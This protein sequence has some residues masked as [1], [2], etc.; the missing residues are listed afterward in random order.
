V[1]SLLTLVEPNSVVIES[2]DEN[3]MIVDF[4]LNEL[5]ISTPVG[6]LLAVG[7]LGIVDD[8]LASVSWRND[9]LR[10][11]ATEREKNVLWVWC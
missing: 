6:W 2:P 9:L 10:T 11:I 4:A 3:E 5:F 8:M 7:E 1:E